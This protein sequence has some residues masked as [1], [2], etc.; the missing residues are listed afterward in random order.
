MQSPPSTS[1]KQSIKLA[2]MYKRE[3][4][5]NQHRRGE[6]DIPN[7]SRGVNTMQ[8]E[9]GS[10]RLTAPDEH[11]VPE[12]PTVNPLLPPL[13]AERPQSFKNQDERSN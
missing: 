2:L 13:P 12:T 3:N 4:L 9:T 5:E 11:E 1:R 10:P 6:I 8:S 7:S